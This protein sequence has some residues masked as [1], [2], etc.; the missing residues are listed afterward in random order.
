[1]NAQ[2]P[3]TCCKNIPSI[4][5]RD[6]ANSIIEHMLITEYY[7]GPLSGFIQCPTCLSVYHFVTLDWGQSHFTRVIGL[8]SVPSDSMARLTSFFSEV[9]SRSQWIPELL[10]KARDRDLDRIEAFLSE[11]LTQAEPPS[12][13]I[14]W[15]ISSNRLL[16][17]RK[18]SNP[19]PGQ[20]ISISD[21]PISEMRN[22]YDWF[23]D[24]GLA[25]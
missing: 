13:V 22:T 17:A 9:P 18:V 6:V 10:R 25:R 19:A 23:G 12:I 5:S 20:C 21:L 15:T 7:D 2:K 8:S 4:A 11:I 3:I 16:A 14:A 24:L 1:M